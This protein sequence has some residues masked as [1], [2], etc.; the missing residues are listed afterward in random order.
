MVNVKIFISSELYFGCTSGYLFGYITEFKESFNF[1]LLR[2][3]SNDRNFIGNGQLFGEICDDNTEC[4]D[5]NTVDF[6]QFVRGNQN[7]LL[8]RVII[9]RVTIEP[10]GTVQIIL[11]DHAKWIEAPTDFDVDAINADFIKSL[12]HFINKEFNENQ[13]TGESAGQWNLKYFQLATMPLLN[14]VNKLAVVK[15]M[16]D[17]YLCLMSGLNRK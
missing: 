11:Y 16:M 9:N 1:Y 8:N 5:T 3:C 10:I 6:V 17:W 14:M 13:S 2:C 12:G 4:A 15:H 7:I